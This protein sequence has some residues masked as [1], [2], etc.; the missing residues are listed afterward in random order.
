VIDVESLH[1][2]L[3]AAGIATLGI[4]SPGADFI[5]VSHSALAG[6]ARTAGWVAVGVVVGN[7]LWAAAGLLGLSVVFALAPTLFTGTLSGALGRGPP[8]HR[9][10]TGSPIGKP[11]PEGAP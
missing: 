7:V 10:E 6:R 1:I 5:V 8:H 2:A 3:A 9:S 4:L 11:A